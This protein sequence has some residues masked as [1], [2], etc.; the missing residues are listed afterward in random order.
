M[1]LTSPYLK[2]VYPE[3]PLTA[4]RRQNIFSDFLI[5]A[6]VS[7]PNNGRPKRRLNKMKRCNN[8]CVVCPYTKEAKFIQ[9]R[10]F[11]WYLD[12]ELNC[13]TRNIVYIIECN[14][15]NCNQKC[16]GETERKFKDRI[17]EHIGYIR[18]KKID[19]STGVHFNSTGHSLGNMTA[20]ILEKVKSEDIFYRKERESYHIRKFN[21]HFRGLN[22]RP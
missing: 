12:R 17:S 4:Y 15:Q 5:R 18:T 10:Y 7:P 1:T 3:P 9:N 14:L 2:E 20:T 13:N 8:Q 22:L 6:K 21:T 19:K 16:I 11:K